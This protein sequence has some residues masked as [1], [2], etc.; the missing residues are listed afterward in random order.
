M[1]T[2]TIVLHGADFS[3]EMARMRTWLDQHMFKPT[4]F[5][6]KQDQEIITISVDF[7]SNHHAEAFNRH[8]DGRESE[9]DFSLPNGLDPPGTDCRRGEKR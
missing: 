1:R 5:T 8:F 2:V 7:L 4:K 3:A 6:Y 9:A